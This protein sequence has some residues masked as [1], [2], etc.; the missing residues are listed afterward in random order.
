M[1]LF[2]CIPK[3]HS[4]DLFGDNQNCSFARV[5]TP[6]RESSIVVPCPHAWLLW[7]KINDFGDWHF[8][9]PLRKGAF[10]VFADQRAL[11]WDGSLANETIL[12]QLYY[13][14][15]PGGQDSREPKRQRRGA[16][17]AQVFA[18]LHSPTWWALLAV[19]TRCTERQIPLVHTHKLLQTL[20]PLL[21][22]MSYSMRNWRGGEGAKQWG[23]AAVPNEKFTRL[24]VGKPEYKPVPGTQQM[25]NSNKI[26]S[27]KKAEKITILGKNKQN[28]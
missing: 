1:H 11:V 2:V 22:G 25:F 13:L 17:L 26:T 3:W 20:G 16:L 4:G 28:T 7:T 6:G 24:G 27:T 21:L 18:G 14:T 12:P 15:Q 10:P 5:P 8:C 23:E 9:E 19:V